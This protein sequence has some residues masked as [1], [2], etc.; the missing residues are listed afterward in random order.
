MTRW[1][2]SAVGWAFQH[3]IQFFITIYVLVVVLVSAYRDRKPEP[4]LLIHS[5]PAKGG[6]DAT[7]ETPGPLPSDRPK[8]VPVRFGQKPNSAL[9]ATAL[10]IT[11][12]GVP[13]YDVNFEPI[14]LGGH[15]V[16]FEGTARLA[17]D[18]PGFWSEVVISKDGGESFD[19]GEALKWWADVTDEPNLVVA[20]RIRYRDFSDTEPTWATVCEIQ[21]V[22]QSGDDG[23]AVR[24]VR[25]ERV[26]AQHA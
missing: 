16:K 3:P 8:V 18:G 24:F 19:L 2:L 25:Q 5:K 23:V 4:Q 26:Q 1:L 17:G 22:P 15:L 9:G 11:N 20:L 10:L 21:R 14:A 7:P 6:T 13:A 12:D